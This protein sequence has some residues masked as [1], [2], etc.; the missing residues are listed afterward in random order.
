[1]AKILQCVE[2]YKI[3]KQRTPARATPYGG[4]KHEKRIMIQR[5]VLLACAVTLLL[6]CQLGVMSP[7]MG[8][9]RVQCVVPD[10]LAGLAGKTG[11]KGSS[12]LHPATGSPHTASPLPPTLAK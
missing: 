3:L 8:K 2:I 7:G 11:A 6:A 1:M 10:E 12:A 5:A 9:L 4:V